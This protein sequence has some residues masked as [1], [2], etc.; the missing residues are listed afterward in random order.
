MAS[1][2]KEIVLILSVDPRWGALCRHLRKDKLLS[3]SCLND[4]QRLG[5]VVSA[6]R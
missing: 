5:F 3:L 2:F 4:D 1:E 6:V